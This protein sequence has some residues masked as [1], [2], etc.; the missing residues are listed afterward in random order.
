M[1]L[2]LRSFYGKR[3]A[4]NGGVVHVD[5]MAHRI[6]T[7]GFGSDSVLSLVGREPKN[8][9]SDFVADAP[10]NLF[11]GSVVL[12]PG[13][14]NLHVW[15]A[16]AAFIKNTAANKGDGTFVDRQ[17]Q[18]VSKRT[19]LPRPDLDIFNGA[20]AKTCFSQRDAI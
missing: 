17:H 7:V 19:G 16:P 2:L 8:K 9:S 5:I 13:Q 20:D 18:I 3:N 11:H 14:F 12:D 4:V 10:V 15:D 6:A 1:V